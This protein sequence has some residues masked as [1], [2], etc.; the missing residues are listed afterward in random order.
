[1]AATH[2]MLSRE[3]PGSLGAGASTGCRSEG[4]PVWQPLT[5]LCYNVSREWPGSLGAGASTGRR[6]E[7][8]GGSAGGSSGV[9]ATHRMLSRERSASLGAG[10]STGRRRESRGGS[11]GGPSGVAA[12]HRI[13]GNSNPLPKIKVKNAITEKI[14]FSHK[15]IGKFQIYFKSSDIFQNCQKH[16][17]KK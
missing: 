15:N 8:R 10:A 13:S 7:S 1:M 4:H 16:F 12:T 11:A 17:P 5:V 6:R 9:A 3:W 2:R 14:N